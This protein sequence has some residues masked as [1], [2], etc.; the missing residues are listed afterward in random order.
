MRGKRNERSKME[1]GK[2]VQEDPWTCGE[3]S[4]RR[5]KG[6]IK[7]KWGHEREDNARE[8]RQLTAG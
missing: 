1:T 7:R 4:L 2:G 3:S 5:T 6:T 8:R